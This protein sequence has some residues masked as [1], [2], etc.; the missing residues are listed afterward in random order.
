MSVLADLVR[1][2]LV[3][4]SAA[5]SG[6]SSVA[7]I[8]AL[9]AADG[10]ELAAV[11]TSRPE[12][13][14][15]AGEAYGVR[16]FHDVSAL[17]AQE[18]ID[19]VSVVVRVPKHHELVMA[20]LDAGKHVFSE[21]PLGANFAE[22]EEMASRARSLGVVTAVGL[23][24]RHD[25]SL[26]YI[27]QLHAEGWFGRIVA[28]NVTMMGSGALAHSSADAWMG[29]RANGANF[30]TIFGGHTIDAISYCLN[31]IVELS[32]LVAT[33]VPEWELSDTGE[34][35][36]VDAP[37]S[38]IVNGTLEGGATISLHT[39]SVPHNA[40]GWRMEV[41]GTEGTTVATTS[42]L[43]QITPIT[44]RGARDSNALEEL[45]PPEELTDRFPAGPPGNVGRAYQH[46]A[47]AIRAGQSFSPDFDHAETVHKLLDLMEQS[48]AEGKS[49]PVS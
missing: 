20:A 27:K 45:A 19:L 21:W 49:V 28:V 32:A 10:I 18:D 41:Y 11:C 16:S 13:A 5:E 37:D 38:V 47:E 3:G 44:L 4:A 23:Q 35:I 22:A 31:P 33:Q 1:V 43:P 39:A 34:T 17:A 29:V 8:P 40:S 26:A 2:G 15:A 36:A 25:P 46:L 14:A 9:R 30:L 6:W 42:G 12:S 7:H 24:G 48:S